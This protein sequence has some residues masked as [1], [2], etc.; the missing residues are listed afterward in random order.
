MTIYHNLCLFFVD[1]LLEAKSGTGKTAVFT[2]IALEKLDLQKG[3]QVI[4]L[5]PTREI[6]AQ[7]C[8]VIR[9]IGV[10]YSGLGVEVVMGGLPLQEDVHKLKS[11]LVHIVVGSPGRLKHLII[12]KHLNVSAVRLLVLDECDKLV[13]KSFLADISSIFSI[14]PKEKQVIMSSA[15][16]PEKCKAFI[17][18]FVH[19]AQHIC[20]D[21][22]TVL[23]GITQKVTLVKYNNNI[24]KQTQNRL[25]ELL[26]ILTTNQF[27]QCL[28]FCNY[29]AR[30]TELHKFLTREKWPVEILY[31]RQE[32]SN[33]L[34]ALK[35]L[36]E[37][38]CR[39]LVS[40]DLAARGIDASNIDLVINF[41]PPY[42]WQTY[43]HRI[44]RAGRYGSFG[45]AI[46]I[47]CE[48]KEVTTFKELFYS[49]NLSLNLRDLWTNNEFS[50]GIQ[51]SLDTMDMDKSYFINSEKDVAPNATDEG[52]WN[53][54]TRKTEKS[55]DSLQTFDELQKSF[56]LTCSPHDKI[57][58]FTDLITSFE[59]P[60]G[61]TKGNIKYS[62]V[63]IT[64]FSIKD[65]ISCLPNE[66]NFTKYNESTNV[67]N[68]K[69]NAI[70]PVPSV[71]SE[72]SKE[73]VTLNLNGIPCQ[74]KD[75]DENYHCEY[76]SKVAKPK[77]NTSSYN[78]EISSAHEKNIYDHSQDYTNA[79]LVE[80]GLPTSFGKNQKKK[81]NKNSFNKCGINVINKKE[82]VA[83]TKNSDPIVDKLTFTSKSKSQYNRNE[84]SN[85]RAKND[86]FSRRSLNKSHS[87]SYKNDATSCAKQNKNIE[88]DLYYKN[89]FNQL[90]THKKYIEYVVYIDEISK[91]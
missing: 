87:D 58:S 19:N 73:E 74:P 77:T 56:E 81:S 43:L 10:D 76:V 80:A 25:Q 53:I 88:F 52:L 39:I 46:T 21:S 65:Y 62:H 86:T 16:Y 61:F 63:N 84:I 69:N 41:E 36:Q 3:V 2:V 49:V 89:W 68:S 12:D 24:V 20:P 75:M 23:L 82:E 9:E 11:K 51:D 5:A 48:G 40:T 67:A 78:A 55:M 34:D 6:A 70:E 47:L 38:K 17:S 14:L 33:R 64:Q 60:G 7:I 79:L 29:Q 22:S 31:G 71:P 32:Q 30:I 35:T 37:Y 1:L 44:G 83:H 8:N 59:Q 45:T 54:L 27:K 85:S 50:K 15:T 18:K 26:K 66:D 72:I 90:K 28:I 4:M 91:L 57:E 42:D 13:E